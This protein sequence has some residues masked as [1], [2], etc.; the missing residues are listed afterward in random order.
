[1]LACNVFNK[2]YYVKHVQRDIFQE[3]IMH[4]G[5]TVMKLW[6]VWNVWKFKKAENCKILM[7]F[8]RSSVSQYKWFFNAIQSLYTSFNIC[9]HQ[10]KTKRENKLKMSQQLAESLKTF[11]CFFLIRQEESFLHQSKR[12][13]YQKTEDGNWI[14]IEEKFQF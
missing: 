1:M 2:R 6:T 5:N 9:Y 3:I 7:I 13:L 8:G 4:E 11:P 14:W 10:L 12:R